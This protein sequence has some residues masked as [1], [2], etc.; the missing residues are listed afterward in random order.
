MPLKIF[1]PTGSDLVSDRRV[2]G[3]N[4]TNIQNL[5]NVRYDWAVKLYKQ[6][7]ENIWIPEK[8]DVVRDV[9]DYINLTKEERKTYDGILS[10]LIFLD[11]VQQISLPFFKSLEHNAITAP[12]IRLCLCEQESQEALHTSSYQYIIETAIPSE[13]RNKIYDFWRTDTILRDR[14]QFIAN[15]YQGYAENP[16]P[17][18]Y[19]NFLVADYLLESVYFFQGFTFFYTLASRQLMTGTADI[20]KL[21]NR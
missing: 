3:G 16:T 18:N 15:I 5:N 10:F 12:E 21:I 8:N 1:N 4:T 17:E 13:N 20:I 2:W 19:F 9:N 7:R 6:M 14:C 11:S